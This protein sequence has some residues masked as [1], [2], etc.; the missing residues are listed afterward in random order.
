M[1]PPSIWPR[2]PFPRREYWVF[3]HSASALNGHLCLLPP[4]LALWIK[5]TCHVTLHST[6]TDLWWSSGGRNCFCVGFQPTK[7]MSVSIFWTH[8][9]NPPP[10]PS[11]VRSGWRRQRNKETRPHCTDMEPGHLDNTNH[12]DDDD[13]NRV[14]WF[15][16]EN[17]NQYEERWKSTPCKERRSDRVVKVCPTWWP[18]MGHCLEESVSAKNL[19]DNPETGHLNTQIKSP[20]VS[21]QIKQ[22]RNQNSLCHICW[23]LHSSQHR[24]YASSMES[25]SP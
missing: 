24:V 5:Y 20:S 14:V 21:S 23:S 7:S 6:A 9:E 22:T 2:V 10:P 12:Y 13:K 4:L 11:E 8:P 19:H 17:R 15:L 1:P 25:S 3:G 18:T 16:E